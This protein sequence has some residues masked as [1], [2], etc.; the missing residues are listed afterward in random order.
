M[1]TT[2]KRPAP[3]PLRSGLRVGGASVPTV[4]VIYGAS[5]DLSQRKLLPAIYNL[6]VRGLLPNRFAV[7]GYARS[8]MD[9]DAFR[10]FARAA[11]EKFSRTPVDDHLWQ[12]FAELLHY[13]SG[14]FDEEGF[15]ALSDRLE[16][17]DAGHGTGGNR[18]Y[19]LSTPASFFPVIVQAMGATRL[20]RPPGFARVVIE[21]PF[22]H[23]L[24]SARELADVVHRSFREN[25]IYRID[26]YLGKET[27]QNIFAFRFAN[28]IFEPVW[29]NTHVDNVQITVGESIGVEHRAAFYEETGVVRDIVQNHL[30]QVFAL[31]AM[32]PP[33]AFDADPI[34]DEKAKLLRATK[35][36]TLENAVRGQYG[37]G[38]VAGE[39]AAA[40]LDEPNVPPDSNTPSYIAAKLEIGNWRWA[41]TPFYIR[42]GKRLAKRVTEV[43]V[44]FKRPPHLPFPTDAVE[45]LEPNA[46]VLRIQPDEGISLRFGAKAPTPSLALRT[47]NMDFLYGSSFLAEVPEAYETLILDAMRGDGTLFTRQDSVE[48]SWEIVDPLLE[49]WRKGTPQVYPAGSWGP[50]LADE[51]LSR[52]GRR[53]RRP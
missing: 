43:A 48:R 51:L 13:Q 17:I 38:Y 34:R 20:N 9:N 21:K 46:L 35:P 10:A 44:Q 53:W 37:D 30:L 23:D 15:R 24:A 45:Q 27:V 50:E 42:A 26:H 12:G 1:A 7:I 33:A 25:Q 19:Y 40:Y 6:A 3:N 39:Q 4:F 52:D 36:M 14:A 31:V 18:V 32:E 29:N 47:V 16:A 8:E 2:A 28:A 41:G 5:G 22:G 49:Q 11:V